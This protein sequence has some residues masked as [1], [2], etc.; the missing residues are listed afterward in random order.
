MCFTVVWIDVE[1]VT[2]S[3][4]M[5]SL[6]INMQIQNSAAKQWAWN[7]LAVEQ[8]A[9]TRFWFYSLLVLV[10]CWCYSLLRIRGA[11]QALLVPL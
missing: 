5:H 9:Q 2:K 11:L 1:E 4:L 3:F 7:G 8:P 10:C 6:C